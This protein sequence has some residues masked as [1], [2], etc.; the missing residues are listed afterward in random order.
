VDES[1]NLMLCT[2]E[3]TK[4]VPS[5]AMQGADQDSRA[6]ETGKLKVAQLTMNVKFEGFTLLQKSAESIDLISAIF[7]GFATLLFFLGLS[8]LMRELHI[9]LEMLQ[10]FD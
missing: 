5:C 2:L 9:I 1:E 6:T 10:A 4:A 7:E 8:K 3:G